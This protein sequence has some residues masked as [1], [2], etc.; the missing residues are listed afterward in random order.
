[1]AF[2]RC[3]SRLMMDRI[4]FLGTGIDELPN[5]KSTITILRKRWCFKRYS[6]LFEFFWRRCLHEDEFYDT[7]YISD[8]ATICTGIA[9]L[10]ECCCVQVLQE[11]VLLCHIQKRFTNHQEELKEL[12]I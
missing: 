8:V 4:I 6:D 1:M 12:T 9:L 10:W 3:F 2:L 11:N 7:Q 5:C